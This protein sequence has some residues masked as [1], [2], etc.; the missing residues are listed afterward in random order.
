MAEELE[1]VKK[2]KITLETE[3]KSICD[4]NQKLRQ[5][6]TELEKKMGRKAQEDLNRRDEVSAILSP[7]IHQIPL[8]Q[9]QTVQA[10]S[11]TK[12]D[13]GTFYFKRNCMCCGMHKHD[14]K[15]TISKAM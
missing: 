3:V 4:E 11:T 8:S 13:E 5:D 12:G 10:A 1:N 9:S 15:D 6:L 14:G 7:W 2:E